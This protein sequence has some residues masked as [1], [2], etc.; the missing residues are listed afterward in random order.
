MKRV[1]ALLL[2]V[3]AMA[4][5]AADS[6][7]AILVLLNSQTSGSPRVYR[8]ALE[9]IREEAAQGKVLQEFVYG[10]ICPED[11]A[12]AKYLEHARPKIRQMAE[13]R[14]NALAWY[15]LSI[16]TQD[17]DALRKAVDGGNIQA[18][19]A[20]GT[21]MH[22]HILGNPEMSSERR[23]EVAKAIFEVF[24]KA[25]AAK[26]ANGLYNLGMCYMTGLGVD[27]NPEL[28]FDA[29]RS[30]AELGHPEAINNLG[31]CYRDGVAVEQDLAQAAKWFEKSASFGN[32]YGQINYALA[33]Q[34]GEGVAQDEAKAAKYFEEVIQEHQMPEAYNLLAVCYMTGRGVAKD[35][36]RGTALFLESAKRGFIPAMDNL[37][38]CY[39]E[40][41]GV[42]ANALKATEWKLRAKAAA[43][44][45]NAAR[46][47]EQNGYK[48]L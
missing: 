35:E 22:N 28:A 26:D 14:N 30:A 46:W 23:E 11:P 34:N 29:F 4:A 25:A 9:Q 24:G 19:N 17:I 43:G 6:S 27:K 1:V 18:Y 44:D 45:I 48:P 8:Q 39:D 37:S 40:G 33:L 47:L 5:V 2:A 38:S 10:A 42:E 31:G 15:L 36:K 7:E 32:P 41:T 3:V 16:E 12:S 21:V 20:W 13:K